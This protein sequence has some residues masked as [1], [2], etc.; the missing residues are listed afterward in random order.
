M[1]VIDRAKGIDKGAIPVATLSEE[2]PLH[3]SRTLKVVLDS[4]ASSDMV[5]GAGYWAATFRSMM[6]RGCARGSHASPS[7]AVLDRLRPSALICSRSQAVPI[8]PTRAGSLEVQHGLES[9]QPTLIDQHEGQTCSSTP[10]EK[11]NTEHRQR[12]PAS[13]YIRC[14]ST[15]WHR[16]NNGRSDR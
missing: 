6:E 4:P 10:A 15:T 11:T 7:P 1:R 16:S 3:P 14:F 13:T 12:T 2:A 9:G 5:P 8:K